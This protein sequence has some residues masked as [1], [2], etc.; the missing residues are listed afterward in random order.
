MNRK[1]YLDTTKGIG[2][3]LVVAGHILN[4][5]GLHSWIYSFHIPLFF[6]VSGITLGIS[7]SWREKSVRQNIVSKTKS[8]LWPYLTFSILSL[9]MTFILYGVRPTIR[10]VA[11][12]II[13]DGILVLWFLP[14]LFLSNILFIII[15]KTIQRLYIKCLLIIILIAITICFSLIDYQQYDQRLLKWSLTFACVIVRGINGC[16]FVYIGY[17]LSKIATSKPK[18]IS[19]LNLIICL[20]LSIAV[21]SFLFLKNS[22][23]FHFTKIGNPILYYT[24]AILGSLIIICLSFLIDKILKFHIL[25][26]YG[27]N[28]IIIFGLHLFIKKVLDLFFEDSSYG[29]IILFVVVLAINTCFIFI[30]NKFLPFIAKYPR[31]KKY[32]YN[33]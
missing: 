4:I 15:E 3:L 5:K 6:I 19:S 1:T 17:I 8:L 27:R 21:H 23:D 16:V 7:N 11:N 18:L 32:S 26:W 28:T 12:T 13:F 24:N 33:S 20:I 25:P 14:A 2:I 31:L 10:L 22:V 29:K 30:I 9:I